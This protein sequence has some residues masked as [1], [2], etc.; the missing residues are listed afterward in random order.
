MG[1]RN[2]VCVNGEWSCQGGVFSADCPPDSCGLSRGECCD[3]A[4]GE[5]TG[6]GCGDDGR[7]RAC[8]PPL[9]H[10]PERAACIPE[11]LGIDDCHD[12]DGKTCET[13]GHECNNSGGCRFS[14]RCVGSDGGLV[15][16]CITPVC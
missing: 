4:T 6:A 8:V 3:P 1:G 10:N 14:C 12:I 16:H 15:W 7:W 5:L 2:A 9:V 11:Y 13:A